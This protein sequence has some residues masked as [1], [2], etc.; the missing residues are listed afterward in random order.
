MWPQEA[1]AMHPPS[2][3]KIPTMK[4]AVHRKKHLLYA[5]LDAWRQV[6]D[7]IISSGTALPLFHCLSVRFISG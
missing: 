2:Q 4:S 5:E 3:Q 7:G 1:A 6:D